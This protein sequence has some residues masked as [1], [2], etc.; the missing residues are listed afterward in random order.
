[1]T[2]AGVEVAEAFTA[3][4]HRRKIDRRPFA[5]LRDPD[6]TVSAHL[7]EVGEVPE[8]PR[9]S[10]R[11]TEWQCKPACFSG[12]RPAYRRV[13]ED[14][15]FESWCGFFPAQFTG[16]NSSQNLYKICTLR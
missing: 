6:G 16:F 12:A 8:P 5:R 7:A 9:A 13:V 10:L 15:S 14:L 4:L 11:L 3:G 2:M 1:M